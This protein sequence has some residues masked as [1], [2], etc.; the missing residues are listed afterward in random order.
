MKKYCLA[1]DLKNNP[2]LIAE[3]ESYHKQVWSVVIKSIRDSGIEKMEIYRT[4]NRMFMIIETTDDFSFREKARAEA[5][6][7]K[8]QDWEGLMSRYQVPLPHARPGE[9]WVPMEKIFEL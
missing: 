5:S 1:C 9:K 7:E 2:K 6:N 3:Y 8:I 4:G